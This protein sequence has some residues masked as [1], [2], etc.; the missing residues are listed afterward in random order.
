MEF[1]FILLREGPATQSRRS[2]RVIASKFG[3]SPD[4]VKVKFREV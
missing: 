2:D 3:S 1:E 4:F